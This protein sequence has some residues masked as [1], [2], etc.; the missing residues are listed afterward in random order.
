MLNDVDIKN[1]LIF[2]SRVSLTGQEAPTFT[3][4]VAKIQKMSE[5][6]QIP[7]TKDSE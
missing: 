5:P 2:L 3:E 4:L 7:P 1:L 6:V